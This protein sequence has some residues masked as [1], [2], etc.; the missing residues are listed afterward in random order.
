MFSF[1]RL[2][3]LKHV[4]LYYLLKINRQPV[5]SNIYGYAVWSSDGLLSLVRKYLSKVTLARATTL[6]SASHAVSN[7]FRSTTKLVTCLTLLKKTCIHTHDLIGWLSGRG[8]KCQSWVLLTQTTSP[9]P[10]SD[11]DSSTTGGPSRH[12]KKH[13]M[14]SRWASKT[15]R[16][17][18]AYP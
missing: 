15:R 11:A 18:V 2:C 6:W 14:S 1:S 4:I 9:C 13:M 12:Q 10:F 3:G 16:R 17:A 7:R 5:I 8:C